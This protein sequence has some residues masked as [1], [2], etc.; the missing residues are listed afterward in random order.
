MPLSGE[1]SVG[2]EIL[3]VRMWAIVLGACALTAIPFVLAGFFF[4]LAFF[5][6]FVQGPAISL[7]A[8]RLLRRYPAT[9]A[10]A[11]AIEGVF[12]MS[13]AAL[14]VLLI[15]YSAA[16]GG[17]YFP[18]ADAQLVR[19]DQ[20][21]GYD[22]RSYAGFA[23]AHP[24]LLQALRYAYNTILFQPALIGVILFMASQEARFEK[25]VLAN[26]VVVTLTCSIFLLLPATTA[27]TFQG[28]EALAVK[29]LPDLPTTTNSWLSD[30]LQIRSGLGRHVVRAAGIIAFPSF[31]CSSAILNSWAVWR[32]RWVRLPFLLLNLT[33]IAATPL[34]GGHYVADLIGGAV[35]AG[36]T[37]AALDLFYRRLLGAKWLRLPA[38]KGWSKPEH[39]LLQ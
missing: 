35:V 28:Q 11:G 33:M 31:H 5:R 14:F 38:W 13:L 18:L 29:I 1:K 6:M 16:A 32:V 20:W 2:S 21:L 7:V 26:M 22:W 17:A 23:A 4:D 3:G 27:W 30:L 25:F 12:L 24:A 8:V 39:P 19:V 9:Y 36:A 15:C 34:I 37:I 10:F